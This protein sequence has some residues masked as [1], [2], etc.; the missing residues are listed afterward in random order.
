MKLAK[1]QF[2]AAF[3]LTVATTGAAQMPTA[4]PAPKNLAQLEEGN[5]LT[6]VGRW[7]EAVGAYRRALELSPNMA[8]IHGNLGHA[9]SQLGRFEEAIASLRR[10]LVLQPQTAVFNYNLG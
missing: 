4:Q 10:A 3:L 2:L 8:E 1:R 5:K 9:Y 6:S 7:A